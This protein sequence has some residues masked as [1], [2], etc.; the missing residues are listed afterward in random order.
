MHKRISIFGCG[1]QKCGT[2]SLYAHFCEHPALSPP[3]RKEIHFF[4]DE[5]NDW[6]AP[7]YRALGAFFASNDGDRLRFDITPI[8]SFWPPSMQRISAYNPAAKLIFLFRPVRSGLVA[9]VHGV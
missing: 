8:Y 3:S 2:T 7:D 5:T 4:D 9:M 6:A 1:V